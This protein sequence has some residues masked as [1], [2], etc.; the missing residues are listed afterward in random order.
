MKLL[1]V[2]PWYEPAWKTGGTAVAVSRL[3]RELADRGHDVTVYTTTDDGEGGTIDMPLGEPVDRGGVTVE[4][5]EPDFWFPPKRS[6]SASGLLSRLDET[7]PEFDV[8]HVA[9]TRHRFEQKVHELATTHDVPYVISPHASLMEWWMQNIGRG[10]LKRF[11]LWR[12]GH[13]VIE[14]A[15]AIHF[16]SDTERDRSRT[17]TSTVPSFVV[18]N[19]IHVGEFSEPA[20]DGR[21]RRTHYGV[22]KDATVLLHLGRVHPQK[23]IH[24]TVDAVAEL[25]ASGE[26]VYY[27]VVGPVSDAAYHRRIVEQVEDHGIQRHV[28]IHPPVPRARLKEAYS[29]A[30]VLVQP[31]KVEG[32]SM[33][34]I[35]AMARSVPAIVSDKV[36]N[37]TEIREWDAGEVIDSRSDAIVD[38]V[39]SLEADR[40]EELSANAWEMAREVYDIPKVAQRMEQAYEDVLSGDRTEALRWEEGEP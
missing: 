36:G 7:V 4:Y 30:D 12:T 39:S 19:G 28:Q 33:T 17:Y 14:D 32:I 1:H 38:A 22:P 37:A 11:Y 16:L 18:P 24:L 25:V 29:I 35:E 20:I 9:S 10:Q 8:I 13:E 5:Y 27:V 2:T 34:L 23:N 15:A 3:C 21:E 26:E 40:H 31:S 6:F